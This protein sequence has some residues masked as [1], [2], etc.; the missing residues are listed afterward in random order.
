[1]LKDFYTPGDSKI[2]YVKELAQATGQSSKL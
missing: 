2:I 1:M